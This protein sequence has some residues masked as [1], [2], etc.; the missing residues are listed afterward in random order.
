MVTPQKLTFRKDGKRHFLPEWQSN[1]TCYSEDL[2]PFSYEYIT[3][4]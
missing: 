3:M 1:N 2:P 4:A